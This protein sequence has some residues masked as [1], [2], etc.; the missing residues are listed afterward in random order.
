MS[1]CTHSQKEGNEG[2]LTVSS[3]D[4]TL[5]PTHRQQ[6]ILNADCRALN[7]LKLASYTV[8][9]SQTMLMLPLLEKCTVDPVRTWRLCFQLAS[10][11]AA[12]LRA[13]HIHYPAFPRLF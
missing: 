11:I 4:V 13:R 5:A 3:Q 2:M 10:V 1:T 8:F 6:Y 12:L 9:T 7:M